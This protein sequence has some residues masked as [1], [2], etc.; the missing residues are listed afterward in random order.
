LDVVAGDDLSDRYLLNT[1]VDPLGRVVWGPA[2]VFDFLT[3]G[4][5]GFTGQILI[6]DLDRDGWNDVLIADQDIDILQGSRRLHVYHNLG[7]SPGAAGK[8]VLPD[9]TGPAGPATV[10]FQAVVLGSGGVA[11]TNAVRAE[12]LP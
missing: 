8:W 7:G 4:D 5:D 6:H 2:K 3:G 11:I 1:G 9:L 12:L 10:T